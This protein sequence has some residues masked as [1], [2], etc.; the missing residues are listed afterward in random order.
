MSTVEPITPYLAPLEKSVTVPR[1]PED[2]FR[3]FT[4]EMGRWWPLATHSIS[5]GESKSAK[6]CALE[7]FV[8]GE[9]YEIDEDGRRRPWGRVLS[10]DPPALL[11]LSWHPGSDAA[12]AQEVEVS[13][14]RVREGTRVTLVH[15]G[16]QKLGEKGASA[17]ESYGKGWAHVFGEAYFA[18][19]KREDPGSVEAGERR[20]KHAQ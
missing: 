16:W 9:I 18:A 2:A 11:R 7:P 20:D 8:G 6:N 19:C 10:W 15:S 4:A 5:H 17:R 13:F 1:S 12:L 14:V 3:I